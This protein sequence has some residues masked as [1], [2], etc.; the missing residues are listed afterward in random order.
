MSA[1][2]PLGPLPASATTANRAALLVGDPAT[3]AEAVRLIDSAKTRIRFETFTLNGPEGAGI[4]AALRRAQA[5][6]VAVQVILDPK[7]MHLS[8][9]H[10]LAADLVASGVTVH[11]YREATLN[12]PLV[13]IDH[14]KLLDIDGKTALV[15]GTNFD[16]R[17][18][19][20]LNFELQGPA[21]AHV[22]DQFAQ[23]WQVSR[24]LKGDVPA[25]A[26]PPVA[27]TTTPATL[28]PLL[29]D[30]TPVAISETAPEDAKTISPRTYDEA[31]AAIKQAKTSIDLL[32]Y[33][34]DDRK[35]L[36]ALM[37]ARQRGVQVRVVLNP[38]SLNWGALLTLK[39]AGVDVRWFKLPKGI[40]E[41]HAKVAIFDHQTVLGGSTNWVHS[42]NFDN[43]ELG[44]WVGGTIA[45]QV[46]KTYDD[47]WQQQTLSPG[48]LT[49]GNVLSARLSRDIAGII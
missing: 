37:A 9:Q 39:T 47:L 1:Q 23:S 46:Q 13:A 31:L 12:D 10:D 48:H 25:T 34:L 24:P 20:D 8:D 7:A 17:V 2:S 6:G 28:R 33:N 16:R 29:R 30:D 26:L 11:R 36:A 32:M 44:V 21:V 5:R 3:Y 45:S 27:G 49:V 38:D 42:S 14:A 4:V 41:L 19:Y 18:N 40:D 22:Q 15:G 35:E 43:H